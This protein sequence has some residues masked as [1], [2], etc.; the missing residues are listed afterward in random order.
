MEIKKSEKMSENNKTVLSNIIGAFLV[1]GMALVISLFTMPAYIK[2][3]NNEVALGLWFTILSV[4]SWILN[5]DLGIG[6]GLRNKLT[7]TLITN[8]TEESKKYLSSAYISIGVLCIVI[9][10]IFIL[11]SPYVNWNTMFNIEDNIVSQNALLMT[12][13]IVFVGII[14]QLFLKL[15]TSVLYALQKSAVNNLLS[16]ITSVITLVSVLVIP[17]GSNDQNV[18]SMAIVYTIAVIFPLLMATMILFAGKKLRNCIPSIRFFR[19]S[20]AKAVLTLG[21]V[22]LFVQLAYMMIM[23]TNEYM[24]TLL[25]GNQYVTE[26]SIYHKLFALGSTVFSLAMTPIWS[27]VTKALAENNVS[28]IIRLYKLLLKLSFLGFASIV[29]LIPFLQF[30]INIWLKN[31]AI[32]V[33][34]TYAIL[35]SI[36]GGLMIFNSSLSSIAN[37]L[38]KLKTQ[39]VCFC[40]G[41]VIKIPIAWLL[42]QLMSSWIGVVWANV[43]AMGIY[44]LIQPWILKFDL[45]KLQKI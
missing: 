33:N 19:I 44:C 13:K 4:L 22:F 12:V 16:L 20:H 21:G 26:Y 23:G 24:I 25:C 18:I 35:F 9:S 3:F 8:D 28:W 32:T 40:I 36:L 42:V 11:I 41:A 43:I 2:F 7:V 14:L 1:K 34:Y 10:A 5:F 30:L 38:G 6:N 15:V 31:N 29:L 37:G 39:A 17:S 27:A 45:I